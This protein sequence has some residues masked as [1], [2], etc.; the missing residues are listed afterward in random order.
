MT[1]P[2]RVL[3]AVVNMNRGG[4]ETLIMNLYK[5][6]NRKEIQ[7]DFLTSFEGAYDE[8]IRKLGG[9][10]YR[11]PSIREG[12]TKYL[13]TLDSFFT[14][15][16]YKIVHAHMD[17]LSGNI[18]ERAKM[19]GVPVRIAHSHNTMSEGNT[20]MK[21]YKWNIGKKIKDSSTHQI[22]C[23][24][25]AGQWLFPDN[26]SYL[27][28]TNS[29]NTG[30]FLFDRMQRRRIRTALG[31]TEKHTLFGTVGRLQPQ[32]NQKYLIKRFAAVYQQNKKAR[33][34]I[35]GDG[36]LKEELQLLAEN[37]R[38]DKAVI[39]TGIRKEIPAFLHAMD[40]FC[41]P[42]LHEG[43][44][45]SVIEAQAAGLYCILSD[46]ITR[47][48]D[49]GAGLCNYL[50]LKE[51]SSWENEMLRARSR[52][53]ARRSPKIDAGIKSFD[54]AESARVLENFYVGR[55]RELRYG[56]IND[57]YSHV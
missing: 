54:A 29:I 8:E 30:D 32:K 26:T 27:L 51:T 45:V 9:R 47:D 43:M 7:F 41:F 14:A 28:L 25:E 53:D 10:I 11:I 3:H 35:I 6:I 50:A 57:I 36:P 23:S 4:A 13:N 5:N 49:I 33:L 21:L 20:V 40:V 42:S 2:V 55:E 12:H 48:V 34:I 31:L 39:F 17:K 52:G 22:A 44:P 19:A 37:L 15:H 46:V 24:K 38:I 18:L 56:K 1:K 16:P